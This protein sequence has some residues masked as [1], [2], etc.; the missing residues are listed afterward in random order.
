[1]PKKSMMMLTEEPFK[2]KCPRCH[3]KAVVDVPLGL[4]ELFFDF[5]TNTPW[6]WQGQPGMPTY[7]ETW[8]YLKSMNVAQ[9]AERLLRAMAHR[10]LVESSLDIRTIHKVSYD[11]DYPGWIMYA[12]V[13][14]DP[15]RMLST[16]IPQ[17]DF[18]P[19]KNEEER[20]RFIIAH[21]INDTLNEMWSSAMKEMSERFDLISQL[22]EST[23][24]LQEHL[25][26]AVLSM[27][28]QGKTDEEI[29]SIMSRKRVG[30]DWMPSQH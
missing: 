11:L 6:W 29:V 8:D 4:R 20:K 13:P 12:M 2:D 14:I 24:G 15:T 17:S 25:R 16:K 10:L 3:K 19:G 5:Q 1:M 27:K 22:M 28:G 9:V 26:K 23:R 18:W 30:D 21:Y 7:F